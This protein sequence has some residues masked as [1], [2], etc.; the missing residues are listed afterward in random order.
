MAVLDGPCTYSRAFAA[1]GTHRIDASVVDAYGY[2]GSPGPFLVT[3]SALSPDPLYL[4]DN[5]TALIT[6]DNV[7]GGVRFGSVYWQSEVLIGGIRYYHAIGMHAPSS[8]IG[9]ADFRIP[10]GAAYVNTVIGLAARS[11]DSCVG[12][13]RAAIYAGGVHLWSGNV[14]GDIRSTRINLGSMALPAGAAT[15]RLQVEPIG[16]NACAHTT[17]GDPSFSAIAR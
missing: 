8:G 10:A 14:E 17:W 12:H 6:E 5:P 13:A 9:F 11:D 4:A 2:P 16:S 1:A 15:L 7:Y 3:A